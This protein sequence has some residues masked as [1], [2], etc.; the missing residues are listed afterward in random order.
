MES[1]TPKKKNTYLGRTIALVAL[2]A[3]ALGV[4]AFS[5]NVVQAQTET[6]ENTAP[7][8]HGFMGDFGMEHQGMPG[9]GADINYDALLAKELGITV[10]ELQSARS[11]AQDAALEEAVDK[12]YLTA[13]QA[14]MLKARKALAQFINPEELMAKALGISV[15]EL[16]AAHQAGKTLPQ[17]VE[18]SGLDMDTVRSNLQAA[19]QEALQQAVEDGVI[20]QQQAD[21]L[22]DANFGAKMFGGGRGGRGGRGGPGGFTPGGQFSPPVNPPDVGGSS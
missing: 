8:M 19:Y 6:P 15:D 21:L 12:G 17:L 20:T 2:V 9:F 14:E 3:A 1:V 10:D 5:Y 13:E 7:P 18:E 16:Q 22:E 4:M 11:A